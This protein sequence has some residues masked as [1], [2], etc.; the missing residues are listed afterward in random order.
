MSQ[1][2]ELVFALARRRH[3]ELFRARVSSKT[4]EFYM[5]YQDQYN[6]M[7]SQG[8]RDYIPEEMS[9]NCSRDMQASKHFG[10]V[11]AGRSSRRPLSV[12]ACATGARARWM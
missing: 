2:A 11:G 7:C 12:S 5:R 4:R 8:Y 6:D 1:E 10:V 9:I 3:E